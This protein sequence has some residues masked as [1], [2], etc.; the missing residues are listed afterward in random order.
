VAGIVVTVFGIDVE[1][2]VGV[3]LVKEF[4]ATSLV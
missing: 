1:V 3:L 2:V 4:D